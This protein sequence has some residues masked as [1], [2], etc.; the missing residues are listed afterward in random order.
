M[1]AAN[2]RAF[3]FV[4]P[5]ANTEKG[6]AAVKEGLEKRGLAI[7]SE[8]RITGPE[9][10]EKMLIDNHY[11]AIASKAT[12]LKPAQLNVP[13]EKF[14]E[15]FGLSWEQALADGKV[16]NA[17][18][19]CEEYF[20]FDSAELNRHWAL[21]KKAG[22]LIK[23]GGGFYCGVINTVEGKAPVYVFNGFFMSMRAN[24]VEADA[25]ISYFVVDWDPKATGLSWEGFRGELLGPTDPKDAPA[26]S[27]RRAFFDN[28]KEYGL[29]YEPNVGD[30]AVHASASPFEG[31]AERM[32]WLGQ[33]PET[34]PF[35]KQ[36]LQVIDRETL[37]AWKVDP[38]VTYGSVL[39][40]KKSCFDS[41]EDTD[42]AECLF[43]LE[44]M[45]KCN[46]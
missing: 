5:H 38:Q 42:S 46:K 3:V 8:G 6:V 24:F 30:N 21:A 27:L 11:Y 25:A 41:V 13:V 22:N 14:Q 10:A 29:G 19:A 35:G 20:K 31:L 7:I 18:D 32:N 17:K 26:G 2:N 4:K 15:K 12:L 9:I 40:I 39:P 23:F 45:K 37:D 16:F 34:D 36:L 43:L 33:D 44:A 28:W 1:S